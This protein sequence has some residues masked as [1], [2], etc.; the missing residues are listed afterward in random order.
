MIAPIAASLI[1]PVASSFIQPVASLLIN[2]IAAKGF[3][4]TGKKDEGRFFF[5]N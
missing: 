3:V 5:H 1:A 4:K 2:T